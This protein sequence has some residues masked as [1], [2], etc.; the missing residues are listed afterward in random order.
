M[1]AR[2]VKLQST[3]PPHLIQS[4]LNWGHC[5]FGGVGVLFSPDLLAKQFPHWSAFLTC[6]Q[7]EPL[8]RITS[9]L[10]AT[11]TVT[12]PVTCAN[13]PSKGAVYRWAHPTAKQASRRSGQRSAHVLCLLQCLPLFQT[14]QLHDPLP[15]LFPQVG[16]RL[17][18]DRHPDCLH[19][20]PDQRRYKHR[21]PVLAQPHERAVHLRGV[22]CRTACNSCHGTECTPMSAATCPGRQP[23]PSLPPTDPDSCRPARPHPNPHSGNDDAGTSVCTG[24]DNDLASRAAMAFAQNKYYFI[25]VGALN[26]SDEPFSVQLFVTTTTG[27]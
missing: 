2:A 23:Q 26:A 18:S 27:V 14:S 5:W 10:Q 20:Q 25:M 13:A 22:S 6:P 1:H 12:S 24:S 4:S 3:G 9:C 11:A 8:A 16:L 21:H 7:F 15:S 17:H 19:L